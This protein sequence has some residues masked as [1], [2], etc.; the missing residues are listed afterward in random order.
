ML[1]L[2]AAGAAL[3]ADCVRATAVADILLSQ[4]R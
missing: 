3:A 1:T 2:L 4:I